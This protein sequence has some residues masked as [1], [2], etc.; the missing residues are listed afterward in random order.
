MSDGAVVEFTVQALY[1]WLAKCQL[2]EEAETAF[3]GWMET[4]YLELEK[5]NLLVMPSAIADN[6][7]ANVDLSEIHRAIVELKAANANLAP[8]DH[9]TLWKYTDVARYIGRSTQTVRRLAAR[10]DFRAPIQ[11]N[12]ARGGP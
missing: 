12:D 4:E 2:V 3:G 6:K 7:E 10:R 8:L 5:H 11:V 9:G 1:E